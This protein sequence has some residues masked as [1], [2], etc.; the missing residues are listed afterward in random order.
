MLRSL[1]P[2]AATK[3][4][5]QYWSKYACSNQRRGGLQW[6]A[7]RQKLQVSDRP[8]KISNRGDTR[9]ENFHS[10]PELSQNGVFSVPNVVF[11]DKK[12]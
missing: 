12:S 5:L 1:P 9:A 11:T 8:V 6:L 2:N 10:A 7:R 3:R 4:I